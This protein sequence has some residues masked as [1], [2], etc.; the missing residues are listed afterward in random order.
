M[1]AQVLEA[2]SLPN[3]PAE[4]ASVLFEVGPP[5]Y[6]LNHV[7]D[8][9]Q[10]SHAQVGLILRKL[11][12]E[13]AVTACVAQVPTWNAIAKG[14]VDRRRTVYWNTSTMQRDQGVVEAYEAKRV[15]ERASPEYQDRM[16]QMF[17]R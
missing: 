9:V 1:K 15:Q 2:L 10:R 3:D 8:K 14:H 7:C 13:G 4:A 6:T 12:A 17:V 5:P 11:V 16:M